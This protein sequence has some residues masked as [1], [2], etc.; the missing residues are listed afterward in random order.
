MGFISG[1]R[2]SHRSLFHSLPFHCVSSL[3]ICVAL[4]LVLLDRDSPTVK[5]MIQDPTFIGRRSLLV[6][7][8]W[9]F[10]VLPQAVRVV[11]ASRFGNQVIKL[12]H[13]LY[14]GA[15]VGTDIIYIAPNFP[16]IN[17]TMNTTSDVKLCMDKQNPGQPALVGT[18]YNL[19][20]IR[21]CSI[22]N[23]L[24]IVATF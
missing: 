11:P 16:Y 3:G 12:A 14:Y 19:V 18:F 7:L 4:S 23:Y 20:K 15:I 1:R 22:A 17:R 9:I 2:V 24:A 8:R 6:S 5:F 10:C 13:A 21:R